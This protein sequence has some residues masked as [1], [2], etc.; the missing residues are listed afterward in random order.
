MAC[1]IGVTIW[2][3]GKSEVICLHGGFR[4]CCLAGK[5]K[6]SLELKMKK[7]AIHAARL[8]IHEADV[9]NDSGFSD[10]LVEGWRC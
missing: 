7:S 2:K 6:G 8:T 5:N 1:L 9:R 3:D 4:F 10:K